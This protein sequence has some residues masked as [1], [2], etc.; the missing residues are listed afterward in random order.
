MYVCVQL[1]SSLC[2]CVC[3]CD[4]VSLVKQV[5]LCDVWLAISLSRSMGLFVHA[6]CDDEIK[7]NGMRAYVSTRALVCVSACEDNEHIH[8][9]VKWPSHHPPATRAALRWNQRASQARKLDTLYHL[10]PMRRLSLSLYAVCTTHRL[11]HS[12]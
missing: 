5:S 1:S 12:S 2:V 10:A 11:R 8:A 3:V 4:I 7:P 9:G 6:D